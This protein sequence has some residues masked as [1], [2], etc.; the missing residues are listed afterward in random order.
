[1]SKIVVIYDNLDKS[2]SEL[3]TVNGFLSNVI[4]NLGNVISEIEAVDSSGPHDAFSAVISAYED[5][6]QEVKNWQTQ[7]DFLSS[8]CSGISATFSNAEEANKAD[9]KTITE[10]FMG[11]LLSAAGISLGDENLELDIYNN[12]EEFYKE[13]T[14]F[15][16]T[17]AEESKKTWDIFFKNT[18]GV[19][20]LT[21]AGALVTKGAKSLI[22]EDTG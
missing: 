1:M 3:Q 22:G 8:S 21:E 9:T 6:I 14:N 4:T 2:A 12:D 10:G 20:E 5:R 15:G 11:T 13:Y 16:G 7:I 18:D 19:V 17:N